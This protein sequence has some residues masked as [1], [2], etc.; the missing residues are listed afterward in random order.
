[1]SIQGLHS[2]VAKMESN[3]L[4]KTF[5]N[6][7][8]RLYKLLE[9]GASS[10]ILESDVTA[11][12]NIPSLKDL[13]PQETREISAEEKLVAQKTMVIKLNGGLGTTMGLDKAKSLLPVRKNSDGSTDAFLDVII[14]NQIARREKFDADLPLLFMNSF[15]TSKDTL[16][17]IAKYGNINKNNLP[18][19]IMQHFEPKITQDLLEPVEFPENP[20][21]EWCPPGHG[22]FYAS[23]YDSG[24]LDEY[25]KAGYEYAFVSNADN[26][27]SAFDPQIAL[28]FAKSK[29]SMMLELAD[30]TD[31]D[32]KGGHIVKDKRGRLVLREVAQIRDEDKEIALDMKNHPYFNTNSIWLNLKDLKKK[33]DETQ[34]VIDLPLIA[35][36]KTVNPKDKSTTPVYQLETAIGA[37][38]GSFENSAVVNVSRDRFLPV[39]THADLERVRTLLA[40]AVA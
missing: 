30:K 35:N 40:K 32:I 16:E 23:F 14:K 25:V 22:D 10:Y 17:Y 20:D 31:L 28:F 19:E 9:E 12:R 33:L 15:R 5:V 38:I 37:A 24:V 8:S 11:L 39:K 6:V 1:M 4:S 7:F 29:A 3:G 18:I 26:L 13:V 27:G 36:K 34:G 2:A 21:L